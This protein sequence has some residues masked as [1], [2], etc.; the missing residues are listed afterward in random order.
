M[1]YPQNLPKELRTTLEATER[2]WAPRYYEMFYL[3]ILEHLHGN[4]C[5]KTALHEAI[6]GSLKFAIPRVRQ[7]ISDGLVEVTTKLDRARCMGPPKHKLWLTE[8]GRLVI[9]QLQANHINDPAYKR[10]YNAIK[11]WLNNGSPKARAADF[12]TLE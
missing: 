5:S 2:P 6:G 9:N 10:Q 12:G 7:Y 8:R 11:V 3:A 1:N 4:A